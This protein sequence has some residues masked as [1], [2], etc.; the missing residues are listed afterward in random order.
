[1]AVMKN[2]MKNQNIT[3]LTREANEQTHP[4]DRCVWKEMNV[5]EELLRQ[6]EFAAFDLTES[7]GVALVG[8]LADDGCVNSCAGRLA[9]GLPVAFFEHDVHHRFAACRLAHF[10]EYP[11]RGVQAAGAF[12]FVVATFGPCGRFGFGGILVRLGGSFRNGGRRGR[13]RGR[14]L[15]LSLPRPA[16]ALCVFMPRE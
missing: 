9:V 10:F 7:R 4:K 2:Y 16:K 11:G 5:P 13:R 3:G 1:M 6:S 14:L 8:Y 15:C 12:G